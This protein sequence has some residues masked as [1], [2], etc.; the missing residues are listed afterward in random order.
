MDL[1][2]ND[3]ISERKE[4]MSMKQLIAKICGVSI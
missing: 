3:L 1:S 4:C 2:M